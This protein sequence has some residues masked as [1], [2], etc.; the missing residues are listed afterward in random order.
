MWGG[1]EKKDF[2]HCWEEKRKMFRPSV[3]LK[4]KRKEGRDQRPQ[5][6]KQS[7]LHGTSHG[8]VEKKGTGRVKKT[9]LHWGKGGNKCP[10][11]EQ[12]K[13]ERTGQKHSHLEGGF[14]KGGRKRRR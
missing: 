6:L 1:L 10:I 9:I 4:Y 14:K 7:S 5:T 3:H 8:A 11:S 13:T 12:K 2:N